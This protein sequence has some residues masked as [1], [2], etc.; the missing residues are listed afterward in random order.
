MPLICDMWWYVYRCPKNWFII[1]VIVFRIHVCCIITVRNEVAKVMFLQVSVHRGGGVCS[2]GAGP[3]GVPG[4]RSWYPSMHWVRPPGRDS[5][6]CRQYASYILVDKATLHRNQQREKIHAVT[7]LC[8]K[9]RSLSWVSKIPYFIFWNE[10]PFG[11]S[12]SQ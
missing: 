2:W 1:L 3:G 4:R 11:V 8:F 7:V 10:V 5:Y 12:V 6:C 9:F